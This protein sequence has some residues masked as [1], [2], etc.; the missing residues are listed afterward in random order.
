MIVAAELERREAATPLLMCGRKAESDL[1]YLRRRG[2]VKV[3]GFGSECRRELADRVLSEPVEYVEVVEHCLR[4]FALGWR[5]E[6]SAQAPLLW[7]APS[8]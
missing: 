4:R 1:E 6:K 8:E 3:S 7:L 2:T 5:S